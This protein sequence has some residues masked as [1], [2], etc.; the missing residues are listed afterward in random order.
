M[1]EA[2]ELSFV[3]EGDDAMPVLKPEVPQALSRDTP[4]LTSSSKKMRLSA[5]LPRFG[6]NLRLPPRSPPVWY[7]DTS[8]VC[9]SIEAL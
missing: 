2:D 7:Y 1:G 8:Q 4:T 5:S 9:Q 3:T 6:M